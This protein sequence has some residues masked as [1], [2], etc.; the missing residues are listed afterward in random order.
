MPP[1]GIPIKCNKCLKVIKR[2]SETVLALQNTW[3]KHCFRC[4]TCK[5]RLRKVYYSWKGELYCKKHYLEKYAHFC[6][7][8]HKPI[9]GLLM[10]SGEISFH[11]EC[12]KCCKCRI[13]IGHQENYV[14]EERSRLYCKKCYEIDIGIY[15]K[16]SKFKLFHKT[17]IHQIH[18]A[19]RFF[20]KNSFTFKV[21]KENKDGLFTGLQKKMTTSK[22]VKPSKVTIESSEVQSLK[23]G[24]TLLEINGTPITSDN[25]KQFS[26]L[27][28]IAEASKRI[29]VT[30]ERAPELSRPQ[31]QNVISTNGLE[32]LDEQSPTSSYSSPTFQQ[33]KSCEEENVFDPEVYKRN[34]SY[35]NF[36][37][38]KRCGSDSAISRYHIGQ[39]KLN[40]IGEGTT[41]VSPRE[42]FSQLTGESKQPKKKNTLV[43]SF[44][45][46]D[47][48]S[49][50]PEEDD[51]NVSIKRD[52]L[53][54]ESPLHRAQS[55]KVVE[56]SS[57]QIFR[58]SDLVIGECIGEGF[59][60]E[61][62]KITHRVT[63]KEMA[64]K[65]IFDIDEE[66]IAQFM[67]EV[68]LLKSLRHPNVLQFIG[69]MFEDK[70][71]HLLLE[72]IKSG[73]LWEL[74]EHK[75]YLH[76]QNVMHRDL[77][78]TNVLL[79]KHQGQYTAIVADF[80]LATVMRAEEVPFSST[81]PK[82]SLCSPTSPRSAMKFQKRTTFVGTAYWMAPEILNGVKYDESVD[83]FSYAI[84]LCELISRTRNDG[85]S[86][87][88]KRDYSLD[89]GAFKKM[90][91][92]NCPPLLFDLCALCGDFDPVKRPS[93]VCCEKWLDILLTHIEFEI[94][95]P[96]EINFYVEPKPL[97][98]NSNTFKKNLQKKKLETT[99]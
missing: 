54:G 64:M 56:T 55:L 67:K 52:F 4:I 43:K 65:K 23:V 10:V 19:P 93:F 77:K 51:V 32:T 24:D 35:F 5:E 8:C 76:S 86:I 11:H 98:L 99:V 79:K 25:I 26:E 6:H 33:Q 89:V 50:I 85:D 87:P 68:H 1:T 46:G 20:K 42:K 47:I 40:V 48:H 9:S 91:T 16:F 60:G 17:A 44:S 66:A 2:Q 12:F 39:R 45:I 70:T 13:L 49:Q 14:F 96:E 97:R 27:L 71:L 31:D 53:K 22:N 29:S 74:I 15:L 88:R 21:N 80:G 28:E 63:G 78:S 3:H 61:V 72:Y 92:L 34:I 37:V 75:S 62:S 41:V 90:L 69:V 18:V 73:T 94:P 38:L 82:S 83:V 30:L 58:P 59:F 81:I 84:T 36:E 57:N 7:I 95:L